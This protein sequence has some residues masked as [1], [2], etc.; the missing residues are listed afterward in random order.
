MG[1]QAFPG[2]GIIFKHGPVGP[3]EAALFTNLLFRED[4]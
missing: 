1:L 4:S 3:L 2:H